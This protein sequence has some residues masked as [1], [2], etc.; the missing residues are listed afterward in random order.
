MYAVL[1][2]VIGLLLW[3]AVSTSSAHADINNTRVDAQGTVELS[4]SNW[5]GGNGVNVYSNGSSSYNEWGSHS[6]NGVFD[7]EMWQ[8]VELVNRLYL[9]RGWISSTWY[10]NGNTLK[11][12]LPPGLTYQP[13]GSISY[14]SPGDVVT[15]EGY[16]DGHAGIVNS[17]SGGSVQIVNQNTE[18]V[19]SSATFS[20]GTLYMNG[21]SGYTVQGVTHAPVVYISNAPRVTFL[22]SSGNLYVKEGPINAPWVLVAQGVV[23]FK[24]S[25]NRI[26]VLNSSG[27]LSVKEGPINAPW[28]QVATGVAPGNFAV[29]NDG[30]YVLW[31]TNL[32]VK[33]GALNAPWLSILSKDQSFKVSAGDHVAAELTSGSLV[34]QWGGVGSGWTTIATGYSDYAVTN[35]MVAAQFG[36]KLYVKQGYVG[37][38]WTLILNPIESFKVSAGDHVA[39][40]LTSGSLVVQWGGVGSGWTTIS[41]ATDGFD[42]TDNRVA[43]LMSGNLYIKEGAPN[44]VW[45]MV[46][47]AATDFALN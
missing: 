7:G 37:A 36:S 34:V 24:T 26:A 45:T 2:S 12:N 30:V 35:D 6:T 22:D 20:N 33:Q 10:G 23:D 14:L 28:T 41:N 47:G 38:P 27:A 15:L 11:N 42:V 29:T 46:T 44:A 19:Y 25:P 9:A 17:V 18:A 8:C 16:G 39:A 32:S 21:W 13:N 31:G 3:A 5:L 4:G 1:V 40:E 43:N